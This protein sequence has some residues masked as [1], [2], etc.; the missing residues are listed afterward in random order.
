MP[1]KWLLKFLASRKT[2]SGFTLIEMLVVIILIGIL[3]AIALP[4]FL[5]Q[6]A[7]GRQVEAKN[8]IGA[9]NRAQQAYR[10]ENSSFATTIEQLGIGL[11]PETENYTYTIVADQ[12][13]ARVNAAAKDAQALRSYSGGVVI[14]SNGATKTISCQTLTASATPPTI[15]LDPATEP[16]C[17]TGEPMR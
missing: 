17:A 4:S 7:K 6:A 10:T 16:T 2:S 14:G 1:K 12:A 15:T 11:P 13:T 3:S 5:S 8:S 9:L